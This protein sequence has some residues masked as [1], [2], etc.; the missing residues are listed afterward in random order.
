[1]SL[2]VGEKREERR[3]GAPHP[4]ALG[5]AEAADADAHILG[6]GGEGEVVLPIHPGDRDA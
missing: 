5:V 4:E 1:M 3:R 6:A 2:K